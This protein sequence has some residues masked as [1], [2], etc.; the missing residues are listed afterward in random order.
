M[1]G[2]L[3]SGL[4]LLMLACGER[5][6]PAPSEPVDAQLRVE[7]LEPQPGATIRA[8]GEASVRVSARDIAGEGQLAGLGYVVRQA[9]GGATVD[10]TVIRFSVR[11][12]STHTFQFTVPAAL[13]ANTQLHLYGI[14][15][16]PAA[17]ARLTDVLSVLV[18]P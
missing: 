16:G 12:D 15:F 2:L 9:A 10:S 11:A 5:S 1:S 3:T 18:G 7:V 17:E 14:A 8:G 13:P 4:V 6:R